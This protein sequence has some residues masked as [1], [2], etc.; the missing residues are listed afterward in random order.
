MTTTTTTED[1]LI[2]LHQTSTEQPSN[3][4]VIDYNIPSTNGD[5]IPSTVSSTT[6][7]QLPQVSPTADVDINIVSSRRSTK[8]MWSKSPNAVILDKTTQALI[9][10]EDH[11]AVK[12]NQGLHA[13]IITTEAPLTPATG[14]FTS[15]EMS[16]N[17]NPS[18]L[19]QSR[20]RLNHVVM[21]GYVITLSEER[22][23]LGY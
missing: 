21:S 17:P 1:Q 13:N 12:E 15:S 6:N 11:N 7:R 14:E 22:L 5:I 16:M 18:H 3:E 20:I 4:D 8:L 19:R 2:F 9:V 10:M 23:A